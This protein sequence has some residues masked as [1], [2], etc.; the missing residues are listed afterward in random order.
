V[1]KREIPFVSLWALSDDNIR[2]RSSEEVAY[3]FG[4]LEKGIL[5]IAKEA[6]KDGNKVTVIGDRSLL[7]D[8]CQRNILKAEEMTK[9]ETGTTAIIAIGYGGQ[10]EIIRAIQSATQ[11]G[12]DM[13]SMTID[14]FWKYIETSAFPPPDL[15]VRTGWHVR[16]SGFFLFQS[17]YAEYYFSE[18][19]WP[20][21]D[22]AELDRALSSFWSRERKFGK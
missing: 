13:T 7:P 15:I 4:L 14:T 9:D 17:P 19:N 11:A 6:K 20:D 18:K 21:F 12:E 22:E 1:S 16:H 2:N 5:D 8:T 10:E 3:L